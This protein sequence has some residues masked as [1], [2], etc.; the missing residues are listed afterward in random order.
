MIL[1]LLFQDNKP[2]GQGSMGSLHRQELPHDNYASYSSLSRQQYDDGP[3]G[4]PHQPGTPTRFNG[5]QDP[6]YGSGGRYSVASNDSLQRDDP[7]S[8]YDPR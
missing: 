4:S 3:Q 6:P 8:A 2:V 5:Y 1:S 7:Y